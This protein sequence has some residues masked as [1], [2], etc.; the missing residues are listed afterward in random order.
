MKQY[1]FS[2]HDYNFRYEEVETID[3]IIGAFEQ[4]RVALLEESAIAD[5]E[6]I[7][8]DADELLLKALKMLGGVKVAE[9]YDRIKDEFWYA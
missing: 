2:Y 5:D 3:E 8:A 7:H 9:A 6:S 1:D 4:M